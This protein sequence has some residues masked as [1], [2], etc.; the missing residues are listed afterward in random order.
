MA[1]QAIYSIEVDIRDRRELDKVFVDVTVWREGDGNFR[2]YGDISPASVQRAQ[3][4]QVALLGRRQQ[5]RKFRPQPRYVTSQ[6]CPECQSRKVVDTGNG[7]S[8]D[9]NLGHGRQ[10]VDLSELRC[11]ECSFSWYW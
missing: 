9:Y 6:P 3:R 11:E 10:G 7:P 8:G 1:K 2:M 4:A 5:F